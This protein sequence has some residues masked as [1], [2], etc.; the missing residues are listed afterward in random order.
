[1][2]SIKVTKD[3]LT[4]AAMND[5]LDSRDA[6]DYFCGMMEARGEDSGERYYEYAS[7]FNAVNAEIERRG[8]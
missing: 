8:A 6:L 7:L 2:Y 3:T 1:M 5:L 4:T